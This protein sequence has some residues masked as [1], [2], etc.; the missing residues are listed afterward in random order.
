MTSERDLDALL[1]ATA[2]EDDL[3]VGDAFERAVMRRVERHRAHRR[4]VLG[5]TGGL[6]GL[7]VCAA[8]AVLPVP[9]AMKVTG[10]AGSVV[11]ILL[12]VGLCA[13]AWIGPAGA[14]P[15]RGPRRS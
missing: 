7:A 11:S 1:A 2:D 14:A 15:Q 6:A 5:V 8:F 4:L 3:P 13:M 12:L 9:A 10:D